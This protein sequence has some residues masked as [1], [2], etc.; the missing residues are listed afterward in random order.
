MNNLTQA[1]VDMLA[2]IG[3]GVKINPFRN[4]ARQR[5]L[6]KLMEKGLAELDLGACATTLTDAGRKRLAAL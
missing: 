1:E 3:R 4:K 6:G 5:V 2:E